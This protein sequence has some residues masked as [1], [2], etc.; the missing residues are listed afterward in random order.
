MLAMD[1]KSGGKYCCSAANAD[2][3]SLPF[4]NFVLMRV[5]IGRTAAGPRSACWRKTRASDSPAERLWRNVW[6]RVIKLDRGKRLEK[7]THA[8]S[9]RGSRHAGN[10]SGCRCTYGNV[11]SGKAEANQEWASGPLPVDMLGGR[12]DA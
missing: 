4:S 12:A 2:S 11:P 8:L 9:T 6:H 5:A 7:N 3:R 10:P 1:R